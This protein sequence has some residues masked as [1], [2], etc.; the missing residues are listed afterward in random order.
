MGDDGSY[1]A[2]GLSETA[3]RSPSQV[4]LVWQDQRI[5]YSDLDHRVTAAAGGLQH[6]GVEAGDRVA[7]MLGNTPHFVEAFLGALR[8]GAVVVPINTALTGQEVAAIL[9][10]CGAR[11]LV[12]TESAHTVIGEL[13]G[14]VPEHVVMAGARQA[15]EGVTETWRGLVGADHQLASV[16]RR[17]E[18]LAA[19]VYTS[20]TTGEPKGAMLTHGNLAANQDQSLATPLGIRDDDVVLAVLPLFH[21]Y[22]MN[23]GLG[24]AVR[25]GATLVLVERFDPTATLEVIIERGVT[26][27]LGAPPMYVAWLNTPG[28]RDADL[29]GVRVAVSGAAP[30]PGPVLERFR[31]DIGLTIWEGY[32]LTE[33]AP[34]V[35]SSAVG[36]TAKP[37]FVGQPLPD[38]DLRLVDEHGDDVEAGDPGE[39]WI[40]G[41][42]VFAGYW[43]DDEATASALTDDG[44]LRTGDVGVLDD[45]G[46]LRLVDR[47]KDV[48]I[49]SGFNVYPREVENVLHQHPKVIQAAVVGEPHPYTG[50]AVRVFVVPDPDGDLTEDEIVTWCRRNLARFKCPDSVRFVPELPHT[51][52]GKVRRRDLR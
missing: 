21:V 9:A 2:D 1:L 47:K 25:V 48:I 37:G 4:A 3:E 33:A 11:V 43:N 52:T 31:D 30:L 6:L 34:A 24:S 26:V 7:L 39:V 15:I 29:S 28:I 44:W 42:N 35:T 40:R 5:T 27:I 19:L 18:D 46:D 13:G 23:V 32:G 10:D 36:G 22:A 20:G 8:A 16:E 41:P 50:E 12:V 45:D 38:I 49:V 17:P 14:S 51:A